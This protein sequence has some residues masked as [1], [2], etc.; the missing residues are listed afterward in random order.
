MTNGEKQLARQALDQLVTALHPD[1]LN[2]LIDIPMETTAARLLRL[3]PQPTTTREFNDALGLLYRDL[4]A[5]ASLSKQVLPLA[6]AFAD[7]VNV[8]NYCYGKA[9]DGYHDA[10]ADVVQDGSQPMELIL[11]SVA[12]AVKQRERANYIRWKLCICLEPLSWAARCAMVEVVNQSQESLS[13]QPL[14]PGPP[15]RFAGDLEDV[16]LAHVSAVHAANYCGS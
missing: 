16:V 1:K 4:L 11:Q 8:L 5:Q 3:P 6:E 10:L 7:A 14:L 13:G 9:G 2:R 12:A 15:G